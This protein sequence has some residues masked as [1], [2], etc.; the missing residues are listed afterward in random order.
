[1]FCHSYQLSIV[2]GKYEERNPFMSIRFP[3]SFEKDHPEAMKNLRTNAHR[4]SSPFDIHATFHDIIS[5]SAIKRGDVKQVSIKGDCGIRYALQH[6]DNKGNKS[7]LLV[8]K[9]AIGSSRVHIFR[10]TEIPQKHS[11]QEY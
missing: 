6:A 10:N 2:I 9:V 1:M 8:G 4:L 5:Y 3:P 11:F 7:T